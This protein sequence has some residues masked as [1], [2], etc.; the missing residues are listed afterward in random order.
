MLDAVGLDLVVGSEVLGERC[1][2]GC[3]ELLVDFEQL[4]DDLLDVLIGRI[5]ACLLHKLDDELV[6]ELGRDEKL[7][8]R[9]VG[10][11][12]DVCHVY[13]LVGYWA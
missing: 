3:G 7:D 8:D 13:S 12:G 2:D 9:E 11:G 4:D 5:D 1:D 10:G 6:V